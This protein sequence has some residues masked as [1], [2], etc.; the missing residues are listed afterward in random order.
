MVDT[1]ANINV[2]SRYHDVTQG[3]GKQGDLDKAMESAKNAGITFDD[4]NSVAITFRKNMT[5]GTESINIQG[6]TLNRFN[7]E[8]LSTMFFFQGINKMFRAYTSETAKMVGV[9][10]MFRT[11]MSLMVLNAWEPLLGSMYD[12]IGFLYELPDSIQSVVGT[13]ITFGDVTSSTVSFMS[14]FALL[15]SSWPIAW[16]NINKAMGGWPDKVVKGAS[17]QLR[18]LAVAANDWSHT[19]LGMGA[20][21]ALVIALGLAGFIISVKGVIKNMRSLNKQIKAYLENRKALEALKGTEFTESTEKDAVKMVVGRGG[22][23]G[24]IGESYIG[25]IVEGANR[26]GTAGALVAA[27]AGITPLGVVAHGINGGQSYTNNVNVTN[28]GGASSGTFD[29]LSTL[30]AA[31]TQLQF[32][33]SAGR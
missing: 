19:L 24:A 20:L 18:R 6:N 1:T 30:D 29:A 14:Q 16:Q 8:F 11:A 22:L 27:A 5:K 23:L 32:N 21:P 10:D 15:A 26:F 9:T 33:Q 12:A 31:N 13:L 4:F 25:S 2:I 7:A 17:R 3:G 28:N